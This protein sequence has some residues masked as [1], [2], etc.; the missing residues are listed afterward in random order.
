MTRELM[1]TILLCGLG[2][3]CLV[4]A[5]PTLRLRNRKASE[6]GQENI[7]CVVSSKDDKEYLLGVYNGN[8]PAYLYKFK[9]LNRSDILMLRSDYADY[10]TCYVSTWF[11]TMVTCLSCCCV[12]QSCCLPCATCA[13]LAWY[14]RSE[15]ACFEQ[16]KLSI[17]SQ[18]FG[19]KVLRR[20]DAVAIATVDKTDNE[21]PNYTY[22]WEVDTTRNVLPRTLRY[23]GK[24]DTQRLL[25]GVIKDIVGPQSQHMK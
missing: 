21:K 12:S 10:V 17:P 15:M 7:R 20:S 5:E 2:S 19:E 4:A 13:A 25:T 24:D 16:M 1:M 3:M 11:A 8:P 14:S 22:L 6:A 23:G 18:V 9:L